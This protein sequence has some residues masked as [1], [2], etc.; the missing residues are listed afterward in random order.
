MRHC[1]LA[2]EWGVA[3]R[4][5]AVPGRPVSHFLLALRSSSCSASPSG[6]SA[7]SL[8][9]L[10]APSSKKPL[11]PDWPIAGLAPIGS[12]HDSCFKQR[13]FRSLDCGF[14]ALR[15]RARFGHWTAAALT[16]LWVRSLDCG[17]AH[18][19]AGLFC[20]KERSFRSLDCGFSI[21]GSAGSRGRLF[22]GK[23][24]SFRSLDCGRAHWT[25]GTIPALQQIACQF[26]TTE[27]LVDWW[28]TLSRHI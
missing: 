18:W 15:R 11:P 23:T 3:L 22:T 26:V 20:L 17:Y 9:L 2:L 5:N 12:W 24:R 4:A 8:Q 6:R 25:A 1:S 7:L 21:G 19:I 10:V 27:T 14:S 13:S 16:G 28:L